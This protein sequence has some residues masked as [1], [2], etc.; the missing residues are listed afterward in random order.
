MPWRRATNCAIAPRIAAC[1]VYRT[2]RPLSYRLSPRWFRGSALRQG[3]QDVARVG[4]QHRAADAGH[5]V[6]AGAG[7]A[8]GQRGAL[9]GRV[10]PVQLA[11]PEVDGHGDAPQV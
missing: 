6:T 3:A 11:V 8:P 1:P 7:D 9:V 2:F 5:Q 10:R 4:P